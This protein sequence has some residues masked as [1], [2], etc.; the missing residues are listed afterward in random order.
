[1]HPLINGEQYIINTADREIEFIELI[2]KNI[3]DDIII[4]YTYDYIVQADIERIDSI[5]EHGRH[6]KR[7]LL[8]WLETRE[9][10]VRYANSYL[11]QHSKLKEYVSLEIS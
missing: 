6:S 4:E 10:V 7:F 11:D 8:S 9:D 2:Q 1:M 3:P 5:K